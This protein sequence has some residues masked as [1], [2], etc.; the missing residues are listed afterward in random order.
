MELNTVVLIPAYQP[1]EKLISLVD[2][3]L[4]KGIPYIVIIDDGSTNKCVEVF[5]ALLIKERCQV[6]RHI[7]NRGKGSALKTGIKA[8]IDSQTTYAGI[9]TVDADGQHLVK[10]I[11]R[12][13][14]AFEKHTDQL[15]WG[16]VTFHKKSSPLKVGLAIKLHTFYSN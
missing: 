12:T 3:L 4:E 1:D 7:T 13:I 14:A 8:I 6:I 5:D 9:I 11:I 2:E 16:A 15:Y 10:D